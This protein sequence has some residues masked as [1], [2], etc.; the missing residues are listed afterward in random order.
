MK[1]KQMKWM[2]WQMSRVNCLRFRLRRFRHH[3]TFPTIIDIV[4]QTEQDSYSMYEHSIVRWYR[5]KLQRLLSES[6]NLHE[7]SK[8]LRKKNLRVDFLKERGKKCLTMVQMKIKLNDQKDSYKFEMIPHKIHA[9]PKMNQELSA[10]RTRY[11][12]VLRHG[13]SLACSKSLPRVKK[14]TPPKQVPVNG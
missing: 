2:K 6:S 8:K 5:R 4:I 10:K 7:K 13:L 3:H 11:L 9:R 12:N 1:M 14:A